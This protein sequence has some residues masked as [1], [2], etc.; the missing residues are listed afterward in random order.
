LIEPT[1]NI[2]CCKLKAFTIGYDCH[3]YSTNP[4]AAIADGV[5]T[6]QA[7]ATTTSIINVPDNITISNM[8]LI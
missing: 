2:L 3:I 4:N 6:N 5:G 1:D 7:E 8:K